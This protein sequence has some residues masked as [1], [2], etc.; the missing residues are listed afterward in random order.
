M[1]IR[2]RDSLRIETRMSSSVLLLGR[3]AGND[4]GLKYYSVAQCCCL[5]R[6]GGE[7][8]CAASERRQMDETQCE[9]KAQ[10][11]PSLSCV[12]LGFTTNKATSVQLYSPPSSLFFFRCRKVHVVAL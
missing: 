11:E 8:Q 9:T 5:W 3:T 10:E 2:Q 4:G 1:F 7:N 6:K 12:S